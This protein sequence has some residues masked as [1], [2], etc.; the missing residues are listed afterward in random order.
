M[1]RAMAFATMR[2]TPP[3]ALRRAGAARGARKG[4]AS[5]TPL[6]ARDARRRGALQR[7]NS[8]FGVGA[9]EALVIGVVSLLVFGPK[10]LADIAKQLGATLREF[11]P[12][13]RELQDVSREF[14]DTLRDEIEKPLEEIEKPLEDAVTGATPSKRAKAA[15]DG[16]LGKE[17]ASVAFDMS[18]VRATEADGTD[19]DTVTEEMK[20]A[21]AAAAWGASAAEDASANVEAPI[22]ATIDQAGMMD[23]AAADVVDMDMD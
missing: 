6:A 12:T 9:P 3:V 20:A 2:T 14:Q 17:D 21:A 22:D 8:L 13:I 11:Q 16:A 7:A 10:G 23:A 18:A 1:A 15:G 19:V 5:A 4:A